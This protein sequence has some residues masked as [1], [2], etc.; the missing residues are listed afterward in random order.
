MHDFWYPRL[1]LRS[2]VTSRL[3]RASP[4]AGALGRRSPGWPR[5]E[6]NIEVTGTWGFI[7]ADESTP[8]L[9][10]RAAIALV[11]RLVK[12][13]NTLTP[14]QL[15]RAYVQGETLGNYSYQLTSAGRSLAQVMAGDPE[16]DAIL[17]QFTR[18]RGMV[19]VG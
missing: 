8:A 14:E 7:E 12:T 16:T 19:A 3:E 9:I 10:K 1:S 4:W 13:L 15:A 6:L 5:G 11:L 2:S 18:A 17:G